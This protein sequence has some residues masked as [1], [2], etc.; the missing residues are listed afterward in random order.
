MRGLATRQKG[1]TGLAHG[2]CWTA[3]C[4][5]AG[6]LWVGPATAQA[7]V[8]LWTLSGLPEADELLYPRFETAY[9]SPALHKWYRPR[10]LPESY[11][12]PFYITDQETARDVRRRYVSAGLEGLDWVDTFG[13]RLG[14]GWL[15]YS[16]QQA[17]AARSGSE[18][19][20]S[21]LYRNVMQSLVIATD[22]DGGRS[23]RLMVGNDIA[24]YFTPLTLYKP[25]FDGLRL[26]CASDRFAGSA[27]L[28]RV[29]ST[30]EVTLGGGTVGRSATNNTHLMGGH[31]TLQVSGRAQVGLTYVN[32]H[33]SNTEQDLTYGNPFAGVLTAKQNAMVQKLWVRIRDDS[34]ADLRGGARV[35]SYDIVLVDTSGRE[36]RGQ[37]IGFLPSVEGG[38]G[39]G[40]AVVADGA[41]VL[42]LEYDLGA[43]DYEGIK[44][45]TIT[46]ATVELAVANDYHV[47]LASDL[48]TDGQA[49]NPETVFLPA[50]RAEGNVHDGSNSQVLALP[51][52]LPTA[53]E[54]IGI[55]WD[56]VRWK[57]L[58]VQGE[59]V[60]N[61]QHGKY[62]NVR[63]KHPHG[64]VKTAHAAY[65]MLS[66]DHYPV[67]LFGE[68]FSMAHDYST[69]YWLTLTNGQIKYK[70]P[71]PWLYEFV[72][73]DDDHN[74]IPEWAR[75]YQA[76]SEGVA[77]PGHDEN[78]DGIYD[79]NQNGGR[80]SGALRTTLGE[81]LD[82]SSTDSNRNL[83]PDYEEPFLR[84][85]S[86]RPE[87]LFGVD[88]NHNGTVDRF[89]NDLVA[90]YPYK[91]DHQ[92]YNAY[93]QA[94]FG[95]DVEAV[96]GRQDML[97]LAGD[98]HTEAIYAL[99]AMRRSMGWIGRLRVYE[100]G[101]LVRDDIADHLE[102]WVQ[103]VGSL[104]RMEAVPDYL[105]GKDTWRNT[106]YADLEQDL[107]AGL[108]ALHRAK[109]ERWWQRRSRTAVV[110]DEG[111]RTSGFAGLMSRAEWTIPIGLATLEPRWKGE[112][113]EDR[114]YSTRYP[115]AR[116]VEQVAYLMWTQPLFAESSTVSYYARYGRQIF[117]TQLQ[118]GLELGRLWMLSGRRREVSESYTSR[119]VVAQL[120]NRVAYGGY[121]LVTRAGLQ[122]QRRTYEEAETRHS[123]QIFVNM[124][125]GLR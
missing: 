16:W 28:S 114:P 52:S 26:D 65:A 37:E 101:A 23:Y 27:I 122:L 124:T 98:G 69:S 46:Q 68:V 75:L 19:R 79:Y 57:G 99:L 89:E 60:L 29:S 77:F 2:V 70:A 36:I 53:N 20:T 116:S 62:P 50:A 25:G 44:A 119:T 45:S 123:S 111:R 22:G 104:G 83:V 24:T 80:R 87:F 105:P 39:D 90:D 81:V 94:H 33:N 118:V 66:Y 12:R 117:D 106:L 35:L 41:E 43:L 92:G 56:L 59:A 107:G 82:R 10:S 34:P 6:A 95:P 14:R 48:Q 102:A 61:R 84:F 76:H 91:A 1:G 88:M 96:V 49:R 11:V 64:V 21:S 4:V 51:Y 58:S 7:G 18:V 67:G 74:A 97:L 115:T 31:G 93:A 73:D 9:V 120:T 72:E 113:R 71:V 85:R 13:R 109:L 8:G 55:N 15:L 47:E 63:T 112:Y 38:R 78:G 30:T 100:F 5:L 125:A 3:L 108:R 17:Q 42:L 110:R 121:N 40:G 103:P 54:L 32:A 86:D